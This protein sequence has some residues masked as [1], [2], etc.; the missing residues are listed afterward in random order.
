MIGVVERGRQIYEFKVGHI[1]F[2]ASQ[3]KG[4]GRVRGQQ[5]YTQMGDLTLGFKVK[6]GE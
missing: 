6:F 4:A 2:W 1:K 3:R 5:T